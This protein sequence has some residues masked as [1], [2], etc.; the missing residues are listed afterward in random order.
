[1][2][3]EVLKADTARG[4]IAL[5]ISEDGYRFSYKQIV[6]REPF[7]LSYPYVFKWED[8][9]YMIPESH[10]ASS[11]RLYRAAAF[12]IKWSY[13]C[14]LL[15]RKLLDSSIFRWG[16]KWWLFASDFRDGLHLFYAADL[17]GPWTEH[18]KSP[19]IVGNR[20]ITRCAG[21]VLCAGGRV[22][23]FTQDCKGIYG[24][25]VRAFEVTHLSMAE[26]R[27]KQL[28]KASIVKGTA[29]GWNAF[30]MHHVDAHESEA[31]QW[32]A[33][34]DGFGDP[35]IPERGRR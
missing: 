22:I 34:V 30:G 14:D 17:R 21:R 2:F 4:E 19:L 28:Q 8:Q 10:Q 27:E 26:Y 18:S 11:V 16:E 24:N 13:V 9:Y 33:A 25:Q 29:I 5:A 6:L 3:F 20:Q 12:P 35:D 15:Q 23:R 32:I 1:M 7:H 31:G